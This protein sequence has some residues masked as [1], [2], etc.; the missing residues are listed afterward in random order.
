MTEFLE[1]LDYLV[2]ADIRMASPILIAALGLVIMEKS[3]IINIGCEG[4]MLIG[5]FAA[6][7][8]ARVFNNPWMGILFAGMIGMVTGYL[9]SLIV[10]T[11]KANQIV[12]GISFNLIILGLTN[13][14]NRLVFGATGQVARAPGFEKITI[15]ILSDIP[16]LG[17]LFDQTGPVYI[18]LL[19]VPLMHYGFKKTTIGLK[20]RSVGEYPQAADSAGINVQLTRTWAILAGSFLIAVAG[21]FLSLGLLSLFS[22]NMV[23]GRGYIALAAVIFGNW[24]PWGILL[25]T[26]IFGL[27]DAVQIK[28]Q[29]SGSPIPY[30]LL[31]M[32]PYI[33]TILALSGFMGRS[34]SPKS[35]GKP[36]YS[37]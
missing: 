35:I 13:T 22:E 16:V 18:A 32:V 8:F 15:P 9:F 10:V 28:L 36:F 3:G 19:L 25:A 30:Q 17:S 29:T 20:I 23:S 5:S 12:T 26:L 24:N 31:M 1:L 4:N 37:E 27:G 11:L 7:F 34:R 33:L 6:V 2:Y 14:L 21:G